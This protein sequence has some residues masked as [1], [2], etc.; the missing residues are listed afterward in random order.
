MNHGPYFLISTAIT[1]SVTQYHQ[2][3]ISLSFPGL[4]PT[5]LNNQK[6]SQNSG[7][8]VIGRLLNISDFSSFVPSYQKF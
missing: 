2:G 4:S 8:I 5:K 6:N 1:A 7:K 3:P